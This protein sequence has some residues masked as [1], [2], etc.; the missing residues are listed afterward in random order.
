MNDKFERCF[1]EK[2]LLK[3]KR[4]EYHFEKIHLPAKLSSNNLGCSTAESK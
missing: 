1:S 2:D 4:S 3:D